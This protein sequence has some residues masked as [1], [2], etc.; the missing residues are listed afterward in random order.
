[1]FISIFFIKMSISVAP[2]FLLLNNK[3]VRAVIMQLELEGK[4]EK[5]ATDKDAIKDKKFFDEDKDLVIHCYT[6]TP[7][8]IETNILHNMEH[9]LFVQTYHPVVPTPP[10]NA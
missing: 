5:D 7:I 1:M 8:L 4:D 10:P 6:L 9:A 3:T 2:V